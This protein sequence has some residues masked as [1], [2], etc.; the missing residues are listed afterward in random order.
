M[1]LY[2]M[3][4]IS[5]QKSSVI[6]MWY[7]KLGEN[8]ADIFIVKLVVFF[9]FPNYIPELEFSNFDFQH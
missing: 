1:L 3:P 7:F 4:F 2:F 9:N 8:F 6:L 5:Q